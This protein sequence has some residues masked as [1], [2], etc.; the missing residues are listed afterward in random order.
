MSDRWETQMTEFGEKQIH[1]SAACDSEASRILVLIA[2]QV[3][4]ND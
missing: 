1:T 2:K 4:N 3:G